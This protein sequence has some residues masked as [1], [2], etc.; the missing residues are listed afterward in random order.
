MVI[1]ILDVIGTE[2]CK[3]FIQIEKKK[4]I[5]VVISIIVNM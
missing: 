5:F 4:S 3:P 1:F 2:L